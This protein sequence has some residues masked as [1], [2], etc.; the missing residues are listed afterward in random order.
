VSLPLLISVPHAG[1]DIPAELK[2]INLLTPEQIVE[3]GDEGAGEIFAIAD[4][5]TS[6]VTT[7]IARAF[8]DMNRPE[9]DRASDGIVKTETIYKV[10]IYREPLAEEQIAFLLDH[11]Y[12]PYHQELNRLSSD[13]ILGIDCHT[14]AAEAPP[15]CTDAGVQRPP[16]CLSNGDGT[17]SQEWLESMVDC[18]RESLQCDVSINDPFK[19]G[20][21]IRSHAAE[22]PWMQLEL[23]RASFMPDEDKRHCVLSAFQQWCRS[24]T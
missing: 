19:G 10:P 5:V 20:H 2:E 13:V 11:Y 17:C 8:V 18:L 4:E 21:I 23:S 1:L 7:E 24:V 14:M 3:D 12:R 16:I 22:L 6:L 9:N 15:I